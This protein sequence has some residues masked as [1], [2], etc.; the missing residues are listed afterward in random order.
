MGL[1]ML[2]RR[3]LET[4]RS[5]FPLASVFGNR[6]APSG[7]NLRALEAWEMRSLYA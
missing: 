5:E 7:S 2:Q 1:E 3:K 6:P 4:E